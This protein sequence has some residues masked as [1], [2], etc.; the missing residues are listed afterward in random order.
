MLLT[1]VALLG[2]SPEG[3]EEG[4]WRQLIRFEAT[5]EQSDGVS[6]WVTDAA[7]LPPD[8]P[9]RRDA[10]RAQ[11]LWVVHG[12]TV[13]DQAYTIVT[14]RYE[15]SQS[16]MFVENVTTFTRDGRRLGGAGPLSEPE[17][18]QTHSAEAEA[19]DAV[20]SGSRLA[21]RGQVAGSIAD[22]VAQS[23]SVADPE[24]STEVVLDVDYDGDP[25]TIRLAIRPHSHRHDVEIVLARQPNRVIN[26][27]AVEQPASGPIVER[28][29]RP[30]ERDRYVTACR[31][32]DGR[33]ETPCR[34][35][36]RLVQRGVEVVAPDQPSV[37]VWLEE[38]EPQVA[39]LPM[40]TAV[41]MSI[42]P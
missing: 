20:C 4:A 26:I 21:A 28:G 30:V 8:G 25:D 19:F 23:S 15:C 33:D 10:R 24:A 40:P 11:E 38:G 14:R 3:Q 42:A 9:E 31:M 16:A 27:V 37:L 35:E 36:F 7:V 13:G 41:T 2:L 6:L 5:A 17:F 39:R 29:L 34:T 1:L 32:N 18:R 22:A 12:R